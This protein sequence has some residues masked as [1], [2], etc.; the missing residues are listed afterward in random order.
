MAKISVLCWSDIADKFETRPYHSEA[1][2]KRYP[3]G[4]SSAI[5]L[6]LNRQKD[7]YAEFENKKN[8]LINNLDKY[9]VLIV[10]A[11]GGSHNKYPWDNNIPNLVK[12]NNLG[13]IVM[14][15]FWI[16]SQ[17]PETNKLTGVLSNIGK[18]CEDTEIK[19]TP[20][21][22]SHPILNQIKTYSI[23]DEIYFGPFEFEKDVIHLVT[24]HGANE[25]SPFAWARTVDKGRVCYIQPG[26]E[27]NESLYNE[28]LQQLIINAVRWVNPHAI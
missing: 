19:I 23:F 18:V 15:S 6:F 28:D 13:L 5:A 11:H 25:K 26:H 20:S 22:V 1:Y 8:D 10:W 12:T 2:K 4:I 3:E 16:F 14:H 7:I 24:G 17:W 9:N 27:T 21:N